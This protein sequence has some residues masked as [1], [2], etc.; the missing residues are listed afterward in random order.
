MKCM[1]LWASGSVHQRVPRRSSLA[2]RRPH[3]G[4]RQH[5]CERV[6]LH[7][8]PLLEDS[9]KRSSKLG[10]ANLVLHATLAGALRAPACPQT[11]IFGRPK[12][13]HRPQAT[14]TCERVHLHPHPLTRDRS[15][16][17]VVSER[18]GVTTNDKNQIGVLGVSQPI[19][20]TSRTPRSMQGT[21]PLDDGSG[22]HV[23]MLLRVAALADRASP[24]F[25]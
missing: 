7:P 15:K 22:A 4:L 18:V 21:S 6:H 23:G 19:C 14:H 5:T 11:L 24:I 20:F 10:C 17:G 2:E 13:T 1:R 3:T 9:F 16:R 12:A 8:H 25:T